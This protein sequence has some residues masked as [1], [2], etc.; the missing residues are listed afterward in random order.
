VKAWLAS[1]ST[2]RLLLSAK[3]R[4]VGIGVATRGDVT[5]FV[6]EIAARATSSS[7]GSR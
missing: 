3:Y 7:R 5:T 1:A 6:V 2:R 4:D